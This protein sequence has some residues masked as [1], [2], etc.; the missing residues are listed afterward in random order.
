MMRF[1]CLF[2]SVLCFFSLAAAA[3]VSDKE[4]QDRLA[5]IDELPMSLSMQDFIDCY[6]AAYVTEQTALA[7]ESQAAVSGARFAQ[8]VWLDALYII[9]GYEAAHEEIMSEATIVKLR[10][11]FDNSDD[12]SS[13]ERSITADACM[14]IL[15]TAV[16]ASKNK[17][18]A[19]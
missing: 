19:K 13:S 14:K 4:L 8:S 5:L 18:A 11:S 3:E 9:D 17:A 6:S 1:A 16:N 10:P 7:A 12:A 2:A 15:L